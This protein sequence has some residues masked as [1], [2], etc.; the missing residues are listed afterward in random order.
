MIGVRPMIRLRDIKPL[1]RENG[2][3]TQARLAERLGMD[4]S[5]LNAIV[6]NRVSGKLNLATVARICDVLNCEPG[7]ILERVPLAELGPPKLALVNPFP[8]PPAPFR[9]VDNGGDGV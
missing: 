5:R 6:R 7:E 3:P 9:S 4:R 2:I 1:M 8:Q